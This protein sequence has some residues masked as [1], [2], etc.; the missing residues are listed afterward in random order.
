MKGGMNTFI[1]WWEKGGG[2]VGLS[3]ALERQDLTERT[4]ALGVLVFDGFM[5]GATW[6]HEYSEAQENKKAREVEET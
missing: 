4:T 1:D 2:L 6:W 5:R 3:A